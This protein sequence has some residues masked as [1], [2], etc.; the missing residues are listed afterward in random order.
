MGLHPMSSNLMVVANCLGIVASVLSFVYILVQMAGSKTIRAKQEFKYYIAASAVLT[1]LFA[2]L[3][4]NLKYD[5]G[6]LAQEG[7][8]Q[9]YDKYDTIEVFYL[10]S[11]K[12]PPNLSFIRTTSILRSSPPKIIEQRADGFK[13]DLRRIEIDD[14]TWQAIGQKPSRIW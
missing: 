7:N 2:F 5:I 12:T 4:L 6:T 14:F 3:S 8:F 10:I 9:G 13:V 11:Y 1:A